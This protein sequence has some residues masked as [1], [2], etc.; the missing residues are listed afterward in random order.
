MKI[1]TGCDLEAVERFGA[2]LENEH[3]CSRVFTDEERAH[4]A[5]SGHSAQSAA[6]IYRAKEAISKALG[7]G[8][9]GLLPKELGLVWCES[10]APQVKLTGSAQEQYGHLQLSVSISHTKELAM[11]TCFALE[12]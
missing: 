8:L 10:G 4:I 11:A 5:K 7:R 9:F 6:G 12:E 1:S 2:L 3:F